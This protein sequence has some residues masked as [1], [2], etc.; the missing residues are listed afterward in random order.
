MAPSQPSDEEL[1]AATA[2][3]AEAFGRFYERH[4]ASVVAFLL[5]RT[6]DR[7]VSADLCAEVFAAALEGVD[8]FDPGRAPATAWLFGI[9]QHK[10]QE[11]MRRGR[12]EAA[13]RRR[14][15]MPVRELTDA[16][17]E[18]VEELADVGAQA[19]GLVAALPAE[20]RDAVVARVLEE[21][22][23]G[24]IAERLQCSEAVVR[25][26]LSRGLKRVRSQMAE[27]GT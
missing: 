18:R 5:S 27:E 11:S 21:R 2:S 24:E 8:R 16:D 3:S 19:S 1:L 9:A 14:L 26:R 7:E 20:Q 4:V 6:R 13:A 23:Y 15:G 12:V 22:D 25:K 17:L 10:L